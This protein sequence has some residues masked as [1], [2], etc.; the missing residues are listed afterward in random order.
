MIRLGLVGHPIG[1]SLSPLLHRAALAVRGL[2]GSYELFDAPDDV[3]LARALDELRA[4]RLQGLNA[5]VP[6][7]QAA[8]AACDRLSAL[9]LEVGAVNT[10]VVANG[11]LF[12]WN[13]DLPGLLAAIRAAWPGRGFQRALV[14]GA[15]GAAPAAVL[16]A[17]ALGAEVRVWNRTHA[18]AD[19]LVARLGTGQV[20]A[21]P[22]HSDAD[23]V[24]QASSHGMDLVGAAFE[25]ATMEAR[26]IIEGTTAHAA[27]V[28]LV[29]RPSPTAWVTAAAALGR[30]AVD[31]LGMLVHQA[32]LA[33]EL[34]TGERSELARDDVA[35][36]VLTRAMGLAL[37]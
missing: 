17:R 5:T 21:H 27:V 4:G 16:A 37:G 25:A 26:A 35:D 36:P 24:L 30:T 7:K 10:L 6:H 13:T 23:L 34:W 33:F 28:D 12:G 19:A 2:E 3:A 15:G 31:G 9:A 20:A 32:A 18:R 29:Y 1:K 8:L 11:E 14:V 22:E